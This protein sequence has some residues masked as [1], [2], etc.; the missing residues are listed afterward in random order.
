M[1]MFASI[2]MGIQVVSSLSVIVLVLLQQGKGADMGSS[3]GGGSA[4]SMF[5]AAG[6]ANFLSRTTKWAAILF[7]GA[8]IGLAWV[9]HH[10]TGSMLDSGVMEG[11]QNEESQSSQQSGSEVPGGEVPSVGGAESDDDASSA[12]PDVDGSDDQADNE[13]EVP[14]LKDDQG[15]D[16]G[17]E[18]PS[19]GAGDDASEQGAASTSADD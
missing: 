15:G 7:F 10:P 8:T 16:T 19:A 9:N 2:L 11:F 4:G 14:G 3:F 12:V 13:V 5:G 6:A 18:V 17:L 1:E